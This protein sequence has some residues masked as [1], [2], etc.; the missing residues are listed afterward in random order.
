MTIA[1]ALMHS[2]FLQAPPVPRVAVSGVVQDQS[3]AVL[4]NATVELVAASGAVQ[5]TTTDASGG[6]RFENVAPGQYELRTS[7]EGFKPAAERLRV[8]K[9]TAGNPIS[10]Q[11]RFIAGLPVEASPAGAAPVAAGLIHTSIPLP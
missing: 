7:F 5:T 3:G 6:F 4:Q 2:A 8:G 1:A 11:G 9:A 10:V